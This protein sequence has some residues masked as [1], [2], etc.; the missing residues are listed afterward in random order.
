MPVG[1]V[2]KTWLT[3]LKPLLALR[4]EHVIPMWSM[5]NLPFRP[6]AAL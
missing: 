2:L 4:V 3:S 1:L 5:T 6:L